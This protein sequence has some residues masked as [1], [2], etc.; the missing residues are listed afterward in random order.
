MGDLDDWVLGDAEPDVHSTCP[1]DI[2]PQISLVDLI[3]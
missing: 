3:H 1:V 2:D